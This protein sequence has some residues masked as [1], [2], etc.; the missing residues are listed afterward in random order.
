MAK[1]LRGINSMEI[2]LEKVYFLQYIHKK[3]ALPVK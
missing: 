1:M 2:L 3:M